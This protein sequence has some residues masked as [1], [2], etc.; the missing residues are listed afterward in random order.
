MTTTSPSAQDIEK[1]LMRQD[2][3]RDARKAA[4]NAPAAVAANLQ[5]NEASASRRRGKMMLPAPQVPPE[6]PWL[7]CAAVFQLPDCQD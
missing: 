3:D 5:M 4:G 1:A 2:A 7:L 6:G